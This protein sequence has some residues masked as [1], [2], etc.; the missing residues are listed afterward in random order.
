MDA[1]STT[2]I[3][4]KGINYIEWIDREKWRRRIKLLAQKHWYIVRK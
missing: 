2:G 4:E 1:G 3:K